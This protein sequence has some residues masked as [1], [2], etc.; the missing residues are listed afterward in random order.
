MQMVE[1]NSLIRCVGLDFVARTKTERWN[2]VFPHD[3][4]A[5]GGKRPFVHFGLSCKKILVTLNCCLQSGMTLSQNPGRKVGLHGVLQAS[6]ARHGVIGDPGLGFRRFEGRQIADFFE[7][8]V[9][10]LA[11]A[12][13]PIEM[14]GTGIRHRA[15]GGCGR[16]DVGHG[17]AAF[18]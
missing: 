12:Q 14:N 18:A 1:G 13:A 8:R 9:D 5:V 4:H 2:A 15:Q 16:A 11:G 3:G 7:G 17:Q 10:G 6:V